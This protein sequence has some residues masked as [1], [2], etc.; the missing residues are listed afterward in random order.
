MS[1]IL[2]ALKKSEKERHRGKAPD[3]STFQKDFNQ[4]PKKRQ[5]WP[6]M[7]LAALLLNAFIF[8][9]WL[10]TSG[11]KAAVEVPKTPAQEQKVRPDA[12]GNQPV[13]SKDVLKK[14]ENK[15]KSISETVQTSPAVVSKPKEAEPARDN[16]I[17][18]VKS[19]KE[20]APAIQ[21]Q[22]PPASTVIDKPAPPE[23][24]VYK[25]NELPASIQKELPDFNISMSIYS[26]SPTSRMVKINTEMLHEGQ[27]LSPGLRLEEITQDGVIMSYK[28]YHFRVGLR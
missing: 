23:Y 28:E 27:F 13:V 10:S 9:Y 18:P 1:Y 3:V 24:R 26:E 25:R 20:V 16:N 11:K 21:R 17:S 6:Y 7:V 15:G 19:V 22:E 5:I 8:A 12:A 2:E 4:A 14:E